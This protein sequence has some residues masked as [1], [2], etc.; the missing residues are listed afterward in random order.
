MTMT[1]LDYKN[2]HKI[3]QTVVDECRLNFDENGLHMCAVDGANVAIVGVNIG[4]P[5]FVEYALEEPFSVGFELSKQE[6]LGFMEEY[7]NGLVSFVISEVENKK[8]DMSCFCETTHDIFHDSFMMVSNTSI[9]SEPKVP[10]LISDY[11]F[12][13][14][15]QTLCKITNRGEHFSVV[16]K[17]KTLVFMNGPD[18]DKWSTEPIEIDSGEGEK[19][20][21]S[22]DYVSCIAKAVPNSVPIEVKFSTDWPCEMKSE[23]AKGCNAWWMVAPRIE[24]D[25]K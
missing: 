25:Y 10:T 20:V 7:N 12:E 1:A 8:E 22:S 13:I 11:S 2:M 16:C 18:D 9:R 15:K 19:S 6:E 5:A 14:D 24:S 23:F 17:N 4:I 21:Y 3:I